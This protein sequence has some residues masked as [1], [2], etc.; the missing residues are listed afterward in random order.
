RAPGATG[1]CP[2][3]PGDLTFRLRDDSVSPRSVGT[4]RR[5]DAVRARPDAHHASGEGLPALPL[6]ARGLPE[7]PRPR[8]A[9]GLGRQGSRARLREAAGRARVLKIIRRLAPAD[10]T[11]TP[12]AAGH[13]GGELQAG[14]VCHCMRVPYATVEGAV[15]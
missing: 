14:L 6:R 15:R 10:R 8:A 4:P 13:N 3:V 2:D 11:A 12:R 1:G 9:L 5:D 7:P